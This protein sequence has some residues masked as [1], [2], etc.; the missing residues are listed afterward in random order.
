[1]QCLNDIFLSIQSDNKD[2][3][4]ALFSKNALSKIQ[5]F[6]LS[7]QELFDYYEGEAKFYDDWAGPFV[8]TTKDEDQIYQLMESS[9]NVK[10]ESNEYRFAMQ[11][12]TMGNET[13][14]GLISLYVI[15]ANDDVNPD[16]A[17]WGDGLFLP[18]IHIAVSSE[19]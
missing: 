11:Y 18:G 16:Y 12:V 4:K 10:T 5:S 3:L 17:Y 7:A 9:F 14:I 13:D 19:N 6:D 2:Q 1:M 15:K 8:K